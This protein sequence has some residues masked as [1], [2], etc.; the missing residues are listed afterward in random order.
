MWVRVTGDGDM[1]PETRGG[2]DGQ[3]CE[4]YVEPVREATP[5]QGFPSR[6]RRHVAGAH[7]TAKNK[8]AS[9]VLGGTP[10]GD[11]IRLPFKGRPTKPPEDGTGLLEKPEQ[12]F[13]QLRT[14]IA[15]DNSTTK[16]RGR[17]P[18]DAE[19]MRFLR[20]VNISHAPTNTHTQASCPNH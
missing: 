1:S 6:N 15:V 11:S 17:R 14:R 4:D 3:V 5:L 19:Y 2:G 18:T 16:P 13:H 9:A 12:L 8:D 7:A 10:D 20:V